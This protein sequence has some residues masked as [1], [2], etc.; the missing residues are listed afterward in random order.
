MSRLNLRS[1]VPADRYSLFLRGN[2]LV[3]GGYIIATTETLIAVSLGLTPLT[4]ETTLY[5][6]ISILSLTSVLIAVT[7][8]SK[9]LLVWQEWTIFLIYL[10]TYLIAFSFWVYWLGDLRMLGIIN[11][12]TAVTIV[13]SYTNVLQ[14]LLMSLP[15]LICYFS[16]TWYSIEIT[17]QPGSI[18]REAFFTFCLLPAFM[19]ISSAAFYMNK[20]RKDLQRIKY[21]LENLNTVLIEANNMLKKE[22]QLSEIEMDL[23]SEIQLAIFPAKPPRTTDWDIAFT[24]KPFGAVSG[25]FYDFYC[26]GSS[27]SGLALFDV[28]GHG[29]A[30]ALITIL[31]KPVLYNYFNKYKSSH[32]G[33]VLEAANA[34]LID[35]LE[36]VNLY[37]TGLLLRMNGTEVEYVNAGHPDLLHFNALTES[38]M[39]IVDSGEL[40][41]GHPIGVSSPRSGYESCKFS[42]SPGDLIIIY[43]DGLTEARSCTGEQFGKNRL[44][45][46]VALSSRSNA[47]SVLNSIMDSFNN[48]TGK[49]KAGDDITVIAARKI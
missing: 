23:A 44:S 1:K 30:P 26:S 40:F 48:F 12:L 41:K 8:F 9:N 20:K 3:F 5:I 18:V 38:V 7:Y 24:T 6:S 21:E 42:V 11:A 19:L 39:T 34:E 16:V 47:E 28:S 32:L 45:E 2:L 10:V 36:E 43:S 35:E 46:A 31:A 33:K 27:L 17:G 14:S 13:L 29:V 37:I 25:D 22:Q 49:N 4:Y 15:T